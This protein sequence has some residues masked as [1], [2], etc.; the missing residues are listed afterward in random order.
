M[1][2]YRSRLKLS[3]NFECHWSI[4][5]GNSYGPIIGPYLFLGK[6]VWTSGPESSSKV[7][8]WLFPAYYVLCGSWCLNMVPPP[9]FERSSLE[10][11]RSGGRDAPPQ[12]SGTCTTLYEKKAK[13]VRYPPVRCYLERVIRDMGGVPR[14]RPLRSG[15]DMTGRPGY[16]TME[17]IGGTSAPYLAR[18]PCVPLF[19]T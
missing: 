9:L 19:C 6:F 10:S 8:G 13:S 5:R 11:M 1:D 12:K 2:Q 3:E 4:L 15:T 16:R 14:I 18:T 7:H 17:M